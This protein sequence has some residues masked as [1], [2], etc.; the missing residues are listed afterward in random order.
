MI[1]D[2]FSKITTTEVDPKILKKLNIKLKNARRIR[3]KIEKR[4]SKIKRLYE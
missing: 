4:K 3:V 2:Y 1:I